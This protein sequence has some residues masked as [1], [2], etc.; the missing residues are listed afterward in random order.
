MPAEPVAVKKGGSGNDTRQLLLTAAA[1]EIHVHGYQ[2]ASLSRILAQTDVTKGALYHHFSSKL[3]LGYAALDE[4][5]APLLREHWIGPL[6]ADDIDPVQTLIE[7]IAKTGRGMSQ[8]EVLLGCPVNNL[9]QE[10]SPVDEGFR[11]RIEALFDE[12]RSATELALRR[13][14]ENRCLRPGIDLRAS[15]AF[16]VASLEGCVGMA[17]IAQSKAI[18]LTCADGLVD[19]LQSMRG[20]GLDIQGGNHD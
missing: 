1:E 11:L 7:T 17:K 15:A 5:F 13:A 16:I 20:Q 2:A 9:A 12:W 14:Q 6:L 10:M 19:Y 18:L 8:A 3:A 4:R